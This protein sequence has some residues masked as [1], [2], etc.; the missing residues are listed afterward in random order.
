MKQEPLSEDEYSD[1]NDSSFSN[2]S[3]KMEPMEYG[4]GQQGEQGE[5]TPVLPPPNCSYCDVCNKRFSCHVHL[6]RHIL[7]SAIHKR[8][9]S[10]KALGHKVDSRVIS[11]LSKEVRSQALFRSYARR[12]MKAM[13]TKSTTRQFNN[14]LLECKICNVILQ[15]RS[16]KIKHDNSLAH[17]SRL[18]A[19]TGGGEIDA[20]NEGVMAGNETLSPLDRQSPFVSPQYSQAGP[21][22]QLASS[23]PLA[24]GTSQTIYKCPFASCNVIFND[25]G[26]LIVHM[27]THG[28]SLPMH[29]V[30]K[31][32]ELSQKQQKKCS[33]KKYIPVDGKFPCRRCNRVFIKALSLSNHLRRCRGLPAP[34][35]PTM[36]IGQS[37]Q[38]P[39][40]LIVQKNKRTL[41]YHIKMYHP[42]SQLATE[43]AMPV[44]GA[45]MIGDVQSDQ[46][47]TVCPVCNKQF[48][49]RLH[50]RS[51]SYK[52]HQMKPV[53][54][55]ICKK[56]FQSKDKLHVHYRKGHL[57]M[58]DG[59]FVCYSCF[60]IFPNKSECWRHKKLGCSLKMRL[61][62][63][64]D[65]NHSFK[66]ED[67]L[68]KHKEEEHI[69]IVPKIEMIP[70]PDLSFLEDI[71]NT[72]CHICGRGYTSYHNLKRH[73]RSSHM[74]ESDNASLIS[75]R[76]IVTDM[77]EHSVSLTDY[78]I[79]DITAMNIPP[80]RT[81]NNNCERN[82]PCLYCDGKFS[83]NSNRLS[84][85]KTVCR[86]APPRVVCQNCQME[87]GAWVTGP[88]KHC[89]K[90]VTTR[91]RSGSISIE[92]VLKKPKLNEL[93]PEM[94]FIQTPVPSPELYPPS[95]RVNK[96]NCSNYRLYKCAVGK[97]TFL[98]Q[99]TML[100]HSSGCNGMCKD[101][102]VHCK[103]CSLV[104]PS[105]KIYLK[106]KPCTG[107]KP[108]Q[109]PFPCQRRRRN[110][111]KT[112]PCQFCDFKFSNR[113]SCL[114]HMRKQHNYYISAE[115]KKLMSMTYTEYNPV[116]QEEDFSN[117][118]IG[119]EEHLAE[120]VKLT[121]VESVADQSV[122][123][124]IDPDD[125]TCQACVTT[126]G[127]HSALLQHIKYIHKNKF[128]TIDCT[129]CS[130]NI[131]KRE[132][133]EHGFSCIKDQLANISTLECVVCSTVF[134]SSDEEDT[135]SLK[136]QEHIMNCCGR[137]SM[138][139]GEK[140]KNKEKFLCLKCCMLFS[141]K[142]SL[143]AHSYKRHGIL[144]QTSP[145]SQL[146][147]M[148]LLEGE[149]VTDN[150]L[151]EMIE[152]DYDSVQF[153]DNDE[154]LSTSSSPVINLAAPTNLFSC[155]RCSKQFK[156]SKGLKC[157]K[158]SAHL[159]QSRKKKRGLPSLKCQYCQRHFFN[160]MKLRNH[161]KVHG[162]VQE[163]V[164]T[165]GAE[166]GIPTTPADAASLSPK[167]LEPFV[168]QEAPNIVGAVSE[169]E[170]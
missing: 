122:M 92:P 131:F 134:Y 141:S 147:N 4:G 103:I 17:K 1:D 166:K 89:G 61:F 37:V 135:L 57:K 15:S 21:S 120:E 157:H 33:G 64:T 83:T 7:H 46:D 152:E 60:Q 118:F 6:V 50:L 54:C 3:I 150:S 52:V 91:K 23:T 148:A 86:A 97:R 127:S 142:K 29:E 76:N 140:F 146:K 137:L 121:D 77:S 139:K 129:F 164:L 165:E 104:F 70:P 138:G 151:S 145:N 99:K 45:E 30:N 31:Q 10:F 81:R 88:C 159:Y 102:R 154:P 11:Q 95:M 161:E 125:H 44:P 105:P 170:S 133:Y 84:H 169:P 115:R 36:M 71:K 117:P 108:L 93:Q 158:A 100:S 63:C 2:I 34:K 78:S 19:E 74:D 69:I 126:F 85:M 160:E 24:S 112:I 25:G 155:H 136:L 43:P 96:N 68:D 58:K 42:N 80:R 53:A 110:L 27:H 113:K 94:P 132:L 59:E 22:H 107:R 111:P 163:L 128:A 49:S 39:I 5:S 162:I 20:N 130:K 79:S 87:R 106:H 18:G 35:P 12:Q 47:D 13:E 82:Y 167:E 26:Q 66:S 40:C 16:H 119:Q 168:K 101:Q 55:K 73:V 149:D 51:H 124:N 48:S 114:F 116:K 90:D 109:K 41:K 67:L 156:T 56:L 14:E 75:S 123:D 65:C 8:V 9:S 28:I 32:I 62:T 72:T 144:I 153:L 98:S 143:Y 38:C